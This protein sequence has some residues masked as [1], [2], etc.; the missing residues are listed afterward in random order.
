AY[1]TGDEDLFRRMAD[2]AAGTAHLSIRRMAWLI[3]GAP[4]VADL[5][6]AGLAHPLPGDRLSM[7]W[8]GDEDFDSWFAL[9][10]RVLARM[11]EAEAA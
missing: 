4:E 6:E 9:M 11:P 5:A 8:L 1:C 3:D 7:H 10:Q 2:A